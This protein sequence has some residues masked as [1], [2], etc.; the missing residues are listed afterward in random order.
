MISPKAVSD[1][2]TRVEEM[3]ESVHNSWSESW[4]AI[5]LDCYYLKLLEEIETRLSEI[6]AD[7]C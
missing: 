4:E 5:N 1:L 7:D 6:L 2:H 3:I